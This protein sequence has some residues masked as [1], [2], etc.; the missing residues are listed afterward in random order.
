MLGS[1]EGL[2]VEQAGSDPTDGSRPEASAAA[3]KLPE[4][5]GLPESERSRRVLVGRVSSE[6]LG[7]R[8]E[9]G[10]GTGRRTGGAVAKA[11][12]VVVGAEGCME[13]GPRGVSGGVL[14]GVEEGC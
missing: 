10:D 3:G 13:G 2:E 6:K 12:G 4:A 11:G 1:C 7:T 8:F 5:G 14:G 9:F